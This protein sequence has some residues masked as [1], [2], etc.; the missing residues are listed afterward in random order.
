MTEEHFQ[1]LLFGA[2]ILSALGFIW[3]EWREY[4]KGRGK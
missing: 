4:R 1:A 3:D 2:I